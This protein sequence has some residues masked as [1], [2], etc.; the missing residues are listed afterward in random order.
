M[1]VTEHDLAEQ[2]GVDVGPALEPA[3]EPAVCGLCGKPLHGRGVIFKGLRF[4]AY[5]G[6]LVPLSHDLCVCPVCV[7]SKQP[8]ISC[9]KVG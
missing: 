5:P 3:E 4:G 1:K 6:H 8:S 2:V 9:E 7:A